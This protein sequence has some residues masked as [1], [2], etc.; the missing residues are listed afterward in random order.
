MARSAIFALVIISCLFVA[1]AIELKTIFEGEWEIQFSE[2]SLA[3]NLKFE[4]E[5][6]NIKL[7]VTKQGNALVTSYVDDEKDQ[8]LNVKIDW[9]S[10]YA[11][12]LLVADEDSD[13][14]KQ[15]FAFDFFNRTGGHL[16]S[17]GVFNGISGKAT[18]F[19]QIVMTSSASF[20]FNHIS[21]D[22]KV[23]TT[24]TGA[25]TVKQATPGF[26][27]KYGSM[28]MIGAML[29]VPRL[30]KGFLPQPEAPAAAAAAGAP[31]TAGATKGRRNAPSRI[32]EIKEETK[33][34]N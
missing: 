20:M 17:Q 25:K 2:T 23:I 13:E 8:E 5:S 1:R 28:M 27:Q 21:A 31:P 7:N 22:G 15:V 3:E 6:N 18:G 33:K 12:E 26:F 30:M 4:G 10:L 19:Y 14:Y 34:E 9:D 29:I 11:G 32:E 24:V 16:V